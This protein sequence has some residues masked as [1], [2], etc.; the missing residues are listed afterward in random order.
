MGLGRN[1][2]PED[3]SKGQLCKLAREVTKDSFRVYEENELLL[4]ENER[5]RKVLVGDTP[6]PLLI[7]L[8]ELADAADHL[9]DDH[10]C[11]KHGYEL[12]AAAKTEARLHI[13]RI[14][15]ALKE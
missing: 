5:L 7:C 14:K 4:A 11:D 9:L 1:L 13:L 3:L 10:Q 15:Q 12:V 8:E 6:F 2:Q